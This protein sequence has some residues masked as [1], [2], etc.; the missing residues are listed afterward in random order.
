MAPAAEEAGAFRTEGEL[1]RVRTQQRGAPR[2]NC[3]DC[4]DR[5]NVVQARCL[6]LLRRTCSLVSPE[7][8]FVGRGSTCP[9]SLP[10]S[11]TLLLQAMSP[12]TLVTVCTSCALRV[13]RVQCACRRCW[14]GARWRRF[15]IHFCYL[16]AAKGSRKLS[17]RCDK[18]CMQV[19]ISFQSWHAQ[20][21]TMR[22]CMCSL[23]VADGAASSD[24][25]PKNSLE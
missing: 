2:T 8:S 16:T 23:P 13:R 24:C 21:L 22:A 20:L 25:A 4:L 1:G 5:T 3:I 11:G 9:M 7:A 15:C 18:C 17:Q 19:H 12:A 14:R 6:L 10:C